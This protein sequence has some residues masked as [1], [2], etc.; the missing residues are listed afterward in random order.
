MS[1]RSNEPANSSAR[2]RPGNG[3]PTG[4]PG[5]APM[6]PE[7]SAWRWASVRRSA[8]WRSRPGFSGSGGGARRPASHRLN[9]RTTSAMTSV[10]RKR[11]T[12]T[13]MRV[14]KTLSKPT[15]WYQIASVQRSIPALARKM[16]K[17]TTTIAATSPTRRRTVRKVR[18]PAPSSGPPTGCFSRGA[19]GGPP[20]AEPFER[21]RDRRWIG[22][23]SPEPAVVPS[24]GASPAG[25][26][27]GMSSGTSCPPGPS[28]SV[29]GAS[30]SA[31]SRGGVRPSASARR[32]SSSR[33]NSSNRSPMATSLEETGTTGAR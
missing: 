11:P 27:A 9:S 10:P 1:S 24:S 6:R 33:M 17:A 7:R 3:P 2:A 15:L 8:I 14:Q 12:W 23:G 4:R 25:R 28:P 16:M 30:G 19:R 20:D 18:R 32:R 22:V 29:A 13:P 26:S 31:G 21:G 5:P